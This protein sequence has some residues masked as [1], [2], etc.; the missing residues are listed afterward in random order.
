MMV[1]IWREG[2]I[3]DNAFQ[4]QEVHL[5]VSHCHRIREHMFYSLLRESWRSD[6]WVVDRVIGWSSCHKIVSNLCASL[7]I[8]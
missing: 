1:L 2:E 6:N 5:F 4:M 7:L 8:L 3:L